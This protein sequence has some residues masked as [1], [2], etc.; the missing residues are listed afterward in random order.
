MPVISL[1]LK[2]D[3]K[4]L[5]VLWLVQN[6]EV[7]NSDKIIS[8]L[9]KIR[10]K[11][12]HSSNTEWKPWLFRQIQQSSVK[13]DK[14]KTPIWKKRNSFCV[15]FTLLLLVVIYGEDLPDVIKP[16]HSASSMQSCKAFY[17]NALLRIFQHLC[18]YIPE[19]DNGL[20]QMQ[21]TYFTNLFLTMDDYMRCP[22]FSSENFK[23]WKLISCAI[24]IN[25]QNL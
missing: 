1:I 11:K 6:L 19:T 9:H 22:I 15:F 16:S 7:V 21:K 12:L 8:T 23:C 14:W 25:H 18:P 2:V 4:F 17:Y 5:S 24:T 20:A 13:E 10:W 3:K